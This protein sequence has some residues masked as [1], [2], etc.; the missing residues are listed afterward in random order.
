M[1]E[2][3]MS[4]SLVYPGERTRFVVLAVV[5]ALLWVA[6]LIGTLGLLLVYL[7]LAWILF[8]FAQ[9]AFITYIKGSGVK[10]STAI[11]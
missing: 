5:A 8:L 4:F 6:L 9:S 3:T 7:L 10:I 11:S 1:A 2:N